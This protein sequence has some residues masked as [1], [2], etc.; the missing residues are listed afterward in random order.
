MMNKL[1]LTLSNYKL[2]LIPT[3]TVGLTR[4]CTYLLI[5][6]IKLYVKPELR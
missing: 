4:L 1:I 5:R 6:H 2:I 3:V